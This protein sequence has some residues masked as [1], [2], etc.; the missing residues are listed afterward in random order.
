MQ[1][2]TFI[3]GILAALAAA[4]WSRPA[5]AEFEV[6][7]I[8]GGKQKLVVGETPKVDMD[9]PPSGRVWK[10]VPDAPVFTD[11]SG[12]QVPVTWT[13]C[14]LKDIREGELFTIGRRCERGSG[15]Y[16]AVWDGRE[17]LI[18]AEPYGFDAHRKNGETTI[19]LLYLGE[20]TNGAVIESHRVKWSVVKKHDIEDEK[21]IE[22]AKEA[23]AKW[24][25]KS[26]LAVPITN[27]PID[28]GK[29]LYV[30]SDE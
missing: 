21:R 25:R 2:R 9:Q 11:L 16:V 24:N 1:R 26:V 6:G 19:V 27:P 30:W 22:E 3:G 7:S 8:I 29:I 20:G 17:H 23:T 13:E 14:K 5:K 12:W 18:Y 15:I 10:G 28:G 4:F